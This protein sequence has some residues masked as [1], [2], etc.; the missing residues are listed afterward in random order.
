[1]SPLDV[2]PAPRGLVRAL[3]LSLAAATVPIIGAVFFPDSLQDYE[4]LTWLTLLVPAFLWA[5]QRGWRGVATALALGMAT[6]STTY[7]VTEL[8]G[9]QVPDLLLAVVAL[10]VGISLAIGVFGDRLGRAT[11]DAAAETLTLQDPLTTLP[12]RRHAEL[13]LQLE[14]AAAERGRSL[15]VVLTEVDGL[16][17][18]NEMN[19]RA[20]GDGVLKS[21]ASMLRQH[22]RRMDLAARYG[23]AQFI[24]VLGGC[25][26]EGAVIFAG[27]IQEQM[28]VAGQ[29]VSL[30]TVSAGIA[31]YRPEMRMGAELIHA[32]EQAL[33]QAR[34][35]G[36]DRIRIFGRQLDEL[37][38]PAGAAVQDAAPAV[39]PDAGDG[40]SA[41]ARFTTYSDEA[42]HIGRGR[43][44]FVLMT[45]TELQQRLTRFLQAESFKVSEGGSV[46]E[47]VA[48]LQQDF[49]IVFLEIGG[50]ATGV[51][52]VIRQLRA[53]SPLTRIVGVPRA[54]GGAVSAG[55]LDVRV[56]GHTMPGAD[57]AALRATVRELLQER[58]A[59]VSV[60]LRHRQL[61][62]ELRAKDREARLALAASEARYRTVVQTVQ[63]VIFATDVAGNWTFLNPAWTTITGFEVEESLGRP[64]FSYL[65]AE[66]ATGVREQFAELVGSRTPYYRYDGRWRTRSGA[67]R[68]VELRMQ[69]VFTSPGTVEG[70]T[71]VLADV[72]DRRHAE[73]ALRR[74]EEYFRSLIEHSA[75]MMAVLNADMTVRYV[76]PAVER[77]LGAPP[78][79]WIG[80]A[81]SAWVHPDDVARV[82]EVLASVLDEPGA[83][84][85]AELRVQHTDGEWRHLEAMCRNLLLTPG[86][87]GVVINARDT[88]ERHRSER[89]L[90]ESEELLLRAQK[91]DAIGR[92]AGGVAHDFNNLL[93]AI[94]GHSEL[95][96]GE[97]EEGSRIS[98][99]LLEIHDAA[100]RATSLTRQ[101]LAFSRRQVLQPRVIDL[102]TVIGEVEKML[103]RVIGE[104]VTLVTRLHDDAG[105]VRADAA[106]IEQVLLNLIVNARDAMPNGGEVTV[107]TARHDVAPG[108]GS[109]TELP[110]GPYVL[111]QVCDTGSGMEPEV[112]SKAFEPFFT[113]K[114]P[115]QGTGL[116]LSTVY[117]IVKQSGG[118]VWLET[119]PGSGTELNILLP[120]LDEAAEPLPVVHVS[121]RPATGSETVLLVED[122]KSVRDLAVR[123]LRKQGYEVIAATNGREA[124]E[125]IERDRLEIDLLLT[126]V[127]MPELNG[128]GL[129]R[130][131]RAAMPGVPI[132]FMSGYNEEA[133]L[134]HGVLAGGTAFIEKPF[135]PAVLLD[136]IRGTLDDAAAELA[137]D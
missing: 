92:L 25:T 86:V 79:A 85:T 45:E 133:V 75:D 101:L 6:L 26:D 78:Q 12:N 127:M 73:D 77:V 47:S 66:D 67:H 112:A 88:T 123:M 20:A 120:R 107:T 28:R 111:L 124:L 4:A 126:D 11:F 105:R 54:E 15:A 59:L 57:D 135:S 65:L 33:S 21:L 74:S 103:R 68:W 93:T 108:E 110:P 98:T 82:T 99:D 22:T 18:Y 100:A 46:L 7:L 131:V 76:S 48:Q 30:P 32:A 90:R 23:P 17:P 53:R 55:V 109:E 129:A 64:L 116:G 118:H 58:D 29:T 61:S 42:G 8:L 70:T 102:N 117:G 87:Q 19:G 31:C 5:Y 50:H 95:L 89:A 119:R 91:M 60:Q 72:T 16:G 36:G 49:D 44:A 137:I 39:T 63:E 134:R 113:T 51:A 81:A 130:A 106:Q 115:G 10:Y 43:S 128:Q 35:D 104:H 40:P 2:R 13:H 37:R 125:L 27:R 136:L 38:P 83:M 96:L 80:K 1:M 114:G 71:G 14:F 9:G 97:L 62:G 84:R 52:D 34:S 132:I 3:L 122:E 41:Q 121:T 69:L 56:D 24:S 94:Q